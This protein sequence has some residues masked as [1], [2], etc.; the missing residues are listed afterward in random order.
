VNLA[1]LIDA[2]ARICPEAPAIL[3]PGRTALTFG[4]LGDRL[5]SAAR[6]L[7]RAGVERGDRVA[8][9]LPNGPELAVA[10]LATASVATCAPLSPGLRAED[11]LRRLSDLRPRFL[12]TNAGTNC[13]ARDAAE[14]LRIRCLDIA[15]EDAA[16]AG[17]FEF[18]PIATPVP[19]S[20]TPPADADVVLVLYT[21]GSTARPKL[22][23]LTQGSL[24]RSAANVASALR[25]GPDDRCL[26]VMPLFHIHGFVAALLASLCA[27]A[28]VAC[29][30][31][32]VDG[33]FLAWIGALQPTW[34]T[35]VPTVHEAILAE[36][37]RDPVRRDAGRL[38]FV[39]SASAPL[40]MRVA[41]ELEA[42]FGV[43]VIEA[44]G[45]TEAAH[46][47]TSNPLPPGVRK[48]GSVGLP[49][50][51][52]VAI[53]SDGGRIVDRDASGEIV[54]RGANVTHGYVA[55]DAANAAAFVDGWFR[56]GD[57]GRI[58]ADGYVWLTGRLKELINRGGTKVS[59]REI[60]DALCGHP[61]VLRGVAFGVA[62]P[63][64]GEDIAAAAILKPGARA[65]EEEIRGYLIDRLAWVHVPSRVLIVDAIPS[66]ET[67]KLR[68]ADLP[69]IFADRLKSTGVLP[70]GEIEEF[71]ATLFAEVLAVDGVGATD[72]FFMLGGDSLRGC[73]VIARLSAQ[74]GVYLPLIALFRS[75][76]VAEFAREI[77]HAP[78][79]VRDVKPVAPFPRQ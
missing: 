54:V 4:Q 71:V 78:V 22:V 56:T 15:W 60:D 53:L 63:T 30:P 31:G 34:Y 9:A 73:Q 36:V 32:Y 44:Y 69:A 77:S 10:A 27:G 47:I 67:G 19:A 1:A 79:D 18:G 24:C 76:T 75:P 26:N 14:A 70:Q 74:K 2:Q 49:A 29:A 3:A 46:Q 33:Q 65:T 62:H 51:P 59:P 8:I 5:G 25:L 37:A 39:R 16:P 20:D 40:P 57:L 11:S 58:D 55:D 12:I 43:P 64:L 28:S 42:A 17:M 23:S 66:G 50:G 72:N 35:A 45:M 7:R 6:T 48:P 41:R 68:R 61:A 38:R 21:T 52:E 13:A